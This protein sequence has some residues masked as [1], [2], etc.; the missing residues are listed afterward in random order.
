[1]SPSL[2]PMFLS[3]GRCFSQ[4]A[5]VSISTAD[6]SVSTAEASISTADVSISTAEASSRHGGPA[7]RQPT[8]PL[9]D[10]VFRSA[11][12]VS[13]ALASATAP[14][15]SNE[16]RTVRQAAPR[17]V[18]GPQPRRHTPRRRRRTPRR[19]PSAGCSSDICR[20]GGVGR[21]D[22][23]SPQRRVEGRGIGCLGRARPP[24]RE[25]RVCA[26]SFRRS[27]ILSERHSKR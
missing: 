21:E 14:T 23:P 12:D 25:A 5:E 2:Q 10:R 17:R 6:V 13:L 24:G 3:H 4:T 8:F 22:G 9:G 20:R 26:T 11:L 1:M 19:R 27:P 18:L 7:A 15:R 16:L